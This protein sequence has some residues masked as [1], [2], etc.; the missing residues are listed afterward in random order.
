MPALRSSGAL[1]TTSGAAGP[2]GF[3]RDCRF[4]GCILDHT[5]V[6]TLLVYAGKDANGTLIATCHLGAAGKDTFWAPG[7]TVIQA[8]NGL[9]YVLSGGTAILYIEA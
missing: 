9:W 2:A 1:T 3:E 7:D 6:A 4:K 8:T 5:G